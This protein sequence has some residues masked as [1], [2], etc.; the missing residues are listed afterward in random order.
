[1]SVRITA[2][3]VELKPD[4]QDLIQ[5]KAA[6]LERF[7]DRVDRVD[8]VFSTERNRHSCEITMHAARTDFAAKFENHEPGTAFDGAFRALETQ[9]RNHKAKVAH[10][11]RK[12]INP[13]KGTRFDGQAPMPRAEA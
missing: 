3:H 8:I 4:F 5:K 10:R 6:K 11:K 7:F 2:R 1:M 9:V 12:A 13:A